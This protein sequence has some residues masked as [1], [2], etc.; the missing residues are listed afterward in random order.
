MTKSF[1]NLSFSLLIA[2]LSACGGGG[3]SG[4]VNPPVVV[5]PTTGGGTT[6]TAPTI[7]FSSGELTLPENNTGSFSLTAEDADGDE[8]TVTVTIA[9]PAVLALS[10]ENGVVTYTT[11]IISE[12]DKVITVTA[13]VTDGT[14]SA[15]TTTIVTV[16]DTPNIL[17]VITMSPSIVQ[18]EGTIAKSSTL[19]IVTSDEN[20]EDT[21]VV[22]VLSSNPEILT[23]IYTDGI[24][25]LTSPTTVT[26]NTEVTVSATVSDGH[27]SITVTSAVTLLYVDINNETPTISLVN[28]DENDMVVIFGEIRNE[29]AVVVTDKDSTDINWSI[30]SLE[31]IDAEDAVLDLV[32]Y[33]GVEGSS[34]IMDMKQAPS[35]RL[36]SF[37]LILTVTD[38]ITS[39]DKEFTLSLTKRPNGAP[40]FTISNRISGFVPVPTGTTRTVTY[41]FIDDA[42]E[43]IVMGDVTTWYGNE[44]NFTVT[45]DHTAK[46]ITIINNGAPIEETFGVLIEYTDGNYSGSAIFQFTSSVVLGALQNDTLDYIQVM[47]NKIEALKEYHE[48]GTFYSEVLENLNYVSERE[49]LNFKRSVIITDDGN[50]SVTKSWLATLEALIVFGV[51]E[52]PTIINSYISGI[53]TQYSFAE[54]GYASSTYQIVND[55]ADL[56][57]GF[58]PQI[59]F[60]NTLNEYDTVNNYFSR[61][62]GNSAYGE[63][64]DGKF[65]FKEEFEFLEAVLFK[66]ASSA[67][68]AYEH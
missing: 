42:S 68:K 31:G 24:V 10:Y 40:M 62:T 20:E 8:L 48:I 11:S 29:I 63:V 55:M 39:V 36:I 49:A 32:N 21:L 65:V 16:T 19:S 23:A 43:N 30:K 37:E 13:N 46:T 66:T 34:I 54:S 9:D 47:Y 28:S 41:G 58:L 44:D 60:E 38:G 27:D 33:Y 45:A 7:S 5:P 4:T 51:W 22:T 56:T 26:E 64:F 18:M 1:K 12:G 2:T 50:F 35:S 25:S 6:N 53:E 15:S 57:N 17:P 14:A 3:D 52:D 67:R 61:F 59:S